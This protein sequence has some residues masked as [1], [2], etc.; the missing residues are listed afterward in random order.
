[1]LLAKAKFIIINALIFEALGDSFKVNHDEFVS[2]NN[3]LSEY[4]KM[5]E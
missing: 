4:N 2:V 1:M 3:G 5:E